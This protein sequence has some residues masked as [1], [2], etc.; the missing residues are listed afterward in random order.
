MIKVVWLL[1]RAPHL[2]L[3]E[4]RQWWIEEHA[5]LVAGKQQPQLRKYRISVRDSDVD[6]LAGA[7]SAD[8]DWDGFAEQWFDSEEAFNQVY[9]RHSAHET[10]DDTDRHVSKLARIFVTEHAYVEPGAV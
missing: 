10:R 8:C 3:E 9:G 1:K 7:P 5:P 2:T 6:T 4:F